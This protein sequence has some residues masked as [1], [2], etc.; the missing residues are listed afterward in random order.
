M[1]RCLFHVGPGTKEKP[2]SGVTPWIKEF[3]GLPTDKSITLASLM[4]AGV[5]SALKE[6]MKQGSTLLMEG[7]PPIASRLVEKARTWQFIDLAD[8]LTD[9]ASRTDEPLLSAAA[10]SVLLVQSLDQVRRKK[11]QI[12]DIASWAQAY[13]I[14]VAAMASSEAAKKEEVAGMM[15][16][17]HVVL[18]VSRD[19]GG[20][21]WYQYDRQYREW[22]AATGKKVWG[23][24]NLTIYGRCLCTPSPLGQG[25]ISPPPMKTT[26][27]KREAKKSKGRNRACFKFNFEVSCGRS[28]ADCHYEHVCWYCA[29][30]DHV[31]GECPRAP[32]R[33]N[34]EK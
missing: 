9:S 24:V 12:T 27:G 18:Q 21:K 3:P 33:A 32:K 25:Q 5:D 1:L 2:D 22:A 14:Y 30:R 8:L 11:K 6:G 4:S 34:R 20:N 31:A 19:L 10:G 29:A 7:I 28:E 23:E 16:H 26:P 15:A 17:M 13:A